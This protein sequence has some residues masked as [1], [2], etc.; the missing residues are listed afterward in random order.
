M[1]HWPKIVMFIVFISFINTEGID[2]S[3]DEDDLAVSELT[4]YNFQ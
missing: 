1:I 4:Q 3:T 2:H